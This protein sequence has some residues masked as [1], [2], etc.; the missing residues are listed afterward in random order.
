MSREED[1]LLE[2]ENV[3]SYALLATV[4]LQVRNE[5]KCNQEPEF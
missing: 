2:L 3:L 5:Q 1:V 4:L